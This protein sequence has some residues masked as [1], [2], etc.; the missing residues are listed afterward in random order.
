MLTITRLQRE[1]KRA[2]PLRISSYQINVEIKNQLSRTEIEQVFVNPN[3][4][5]V[6]GLYLFPLADDAMISNIALSIEDKRMK[7]KI[8]TAAQ[9][10]GVYIERAQHSENTPILRYIG[11]RAYAVQVDQIPANRELRIRFAYSQMPS[12]GSVL[13]RY[14]HPLS[15][16]KATQACIE[17]FRVNVNIKSDLD[18]QSLC[19]PSHG[20]VVNDKWRIDYAETDLD[21]DKD[22]AF[23]YT[24]SDPDFGIGLITHRENADEDGYFML[25][26]SPRYKRQMPDIVARDFIFVLD[27]SESMITAKKI[28]RAKE[29]LHYCI[30]NLAYRDRFNIL[31]FNSDIEDAF[32]KLSD[33]RSNREKAHAF[34]EGIEECAGTDINEV[35]LTALRENPLPNRPRIIVLLTDGCP[36]TGVRD[37]SQI[38][39]NIAEA[40]AKQTRIFVFGIG[41]DLNTRFLDKLAAGNGGT[42]HYLVPNEDIKVA[43]SS[44]FRKIKDPVLVNTEIDFADIDTEYVYPQELPNLFSHEQLTL[45]GRYKGHGDTLL[46]LRGL[47]NREPHEFTKDVRFAKIESRF[48]F[49]PQLWAQCKTAALMDEME[50]NRSG[51]EL[52]KEITRLGE[53]YGVL[54]PDTEWIQ[55]MSD[56]WTIGRQN[57]VVR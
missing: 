35:L 42:H 8:L 6:K 38:W 37:E 3:N 40:N 57:A 20:M 25:F 21:P 13:A 47:I 5:E 44:L 12:V 36:T 48:N 22:F 54:T 17:D 2:V 23:E 27:R 10:R 52:V 28:R 1:D 11:T 45:V 31:A 29:A 7:G 50:R 34:I 32:G 4:F 24:V 30:D 46:K 19:L 16:A 43:V 55:R 18:I 49:L 9:A 56:H 41:D 51:T 33:V 39:E 53:V 26:I 15:L 14:T